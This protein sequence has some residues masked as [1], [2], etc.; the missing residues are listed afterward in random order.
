MV[1]STL[2]SRV[3]FWGT[4]CALVVGLALLLMLT[5]PGSHPQP[6]QAQTTT[7]P[8]W[9]LSND[10]FTAVRFSNIREA[11]SPITVPET[12]STAPQPKPVRVVL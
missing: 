6:A 8:R 5:S 12:S 1:R 2:R 9:E 11:V 3:R 10:I 4:V 7:A